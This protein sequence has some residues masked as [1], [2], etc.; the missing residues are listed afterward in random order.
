MNLSQC[1]I[2]TLKFSGNCCE[3]A[4]TAQ[5]QQSYSKQFVNIQTV[6]TDTWSKS[7]NNLIFLTANVKCLSCPKHSNKSILNILTSKTLLSHLRMWTQ[8]QYLYQKQQQHIWN[9][10]QKTAKRLRD[11]LVDPLPLQ[12][13][14]WWHCRD[15]PSPHSHIVPRIIWMASETK[16]RENYNY[17]RFRDQRTD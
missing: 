4:I 9:I 1:K 11:T 17:Y 7:N 13:V 15:P 16:K 6:F 8:K 14:I 12:C 2:W 10:V 5:Q 3:Y